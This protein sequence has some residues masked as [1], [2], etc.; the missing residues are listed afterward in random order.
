VAGERR[1]RTSRQPGRLLKNSSNFSYKGRVF[2]KKETGGARGVLDRDAPLT[3]AERGSI[4]QRVEEVLAEVGFG[5]QVHRLCRPAYSQRAD[6][7]PGID[8][9]VCFK[10][11]IVGFFENLPSERAIAARCEDSLAPNAKRLDRPYRYRDGP[12]FL[13]HFP[14]LRTRLL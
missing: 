9:V 14:A 13:H 2:G 5:E 8:P 3:E 12:V 11:L 1:S 10:M 6:G 7:R 4:F